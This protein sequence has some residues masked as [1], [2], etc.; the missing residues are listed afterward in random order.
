[1]FNATL[2]RFHETKI[3]VQN[4][5]NHTNRLCVF[6]ALDIQRAMRM[7]HIAICDLPDSTVFFHI[8][9]KKARFSR[10][11]ITETPKLSDFPQPAGRPEHDQQ[12]CYHHAPTV[13]P[14]TVTAVVELLMMG[15][16]TPETC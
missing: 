12:H 9:S 6:V 11:K 1:M 3:A 15:V 4:N 2:K 13:Q 8:I 7:R 14:E 16:R 10:K 5:E